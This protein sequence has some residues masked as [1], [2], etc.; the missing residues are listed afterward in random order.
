M[1]SAKWAKRGRD[2]KGFKDGKKIYFWNYDYSSPNLGN[3]NLGPDCKDL[4]HKDW[5]S[6]VLIDWTNL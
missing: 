1:L 3:P 6:D 2:Y 5:T 4:D